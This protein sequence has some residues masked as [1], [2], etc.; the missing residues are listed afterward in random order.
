MK[1][2]SP[3]KLFD[4]H[5]AEGPRMLYRV[6]RRRDGSLAF[7]KQGKQ[8][9]LKHWQIALV[10]WALN[11]PQDVADAWEHHARLVMLAERL[12]RTRGGGK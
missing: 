12:G 11:H 4:E 3:K 1:P 10:R 7:R 8:V 6:R 9:R 2:W 5:P